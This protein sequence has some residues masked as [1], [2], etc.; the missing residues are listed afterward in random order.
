MDAEDTLQ[1]REYKKPEETR[2]A[3]EVLEKNPD[4]PSTQIRIY[5]QEQ[6]FKRI[7]AGN[8]TNRLSD[9]RL[10]DSLKLLDIHCESYL[11][12]VIDLETQKA[13]AN[14]VMDYILP[15]VWAYFA[16]YQ[17]N[18]PMEA[19]PPTPLFATPGVIPLQIQ[20]DKLRDRAQ[21]WIVDGYR[22]LQAMHTTT[23]AM[24]RKGYRA[25]VR[26]WMKQEGISSVLKAAKKLAVSDSTL[27]SIMSNRGNVKYSH[28]TLAE[29]LERIGYREDR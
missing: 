3:F 22:H 27:K 11:L 19:V 8:L 28:E 6:A 10:E 18:F 7:T 14:I 4:F 1:W 16:E 5:E 24:T 25:E 20:R 9:P 23:S 29:I 26:A 17:S 13:F 21:H 15:Q 12:L 2:K